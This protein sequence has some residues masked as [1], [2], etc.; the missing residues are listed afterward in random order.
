MRI[1]DKTYEKGITRIPTITLIQMYRHV[2]FVLAKHLAHSKDM[3][4]TNQQYKYSLL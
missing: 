2:V 4:N 3:L 1:T